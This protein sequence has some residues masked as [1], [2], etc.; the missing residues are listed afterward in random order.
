MKP[1]I[2]TRSRRRGASLIFMLILMPIALM[3]LVGAL[4]QA[5]IALRETA[6]DQ[7]RVQARLLAESALALGSATP[8][9]SLPLRESL[10][11]IGEMALERMESSEG[12]PRP[13]A[14]GRVEH[15]GTRT[16]CRI[17]AI[18]ESRTRPPS[19][20]EIGY[21]IGIVAS[22]EASPTGP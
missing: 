9:R 20:I 12:P 18:Q 5:D 22:P 8:D 14:T 2:P 1:R 7:Q 19:P 15:A 16:Q 21:S 11:E 4:T 13:L 10:D 17:V 6:R 3:M